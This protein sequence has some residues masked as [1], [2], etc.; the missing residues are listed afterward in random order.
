VRISGANLIVDPSGVIDD[1]GL[2]FVVQ[3]AITLALPTTGAANWF[4]K[5]VAGSTALERSIEF[6]DDRGTYDASKNGFYNTGGE[7]ILNW[8]YDR[9]SDT[10]LRLPPDTSPLGYPLDYSDRA[11]PLSTTNDN[12]YGEWF[13]SYTT[14]RTGKVGVTNL[15]N[16]GYDRA[17]DYLVYQIVSDKIYR[18]T[19]SGVAV[20]SVNLSIA[21]YSL[22]ILID[23]ATGNLIV[24]VGVTG[25]VTVYDGFSTSVLSTLTGMYCDDLCIDNDGNLIG[26]DEGVGVRK[27][28]GISTTVLDTLALSEASAGITWDE[29]NNNLVVAFRAG[30]NNDRIAI[31]NG[32]S[33]NLIATSSDYLAYCHGLAFDG[34]RGILWV[35]NSPTNLDNKGTISYRGLFK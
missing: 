31:Y 3:S 2:P 8:V 11:F 15:F 7:R 9:L 28:N 20:D 21:Q 19:T 1:S 12:I 22:G 33:L 26:V 10:L 17:N 29:W 35:I 24:G 23:P 6:T 14:E 5:V 30:S 27:Y 34:S 13:G 18:I 16:L 25:V 32:F 4:L